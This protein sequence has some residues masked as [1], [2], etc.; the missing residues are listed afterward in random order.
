MTVQRRCGTSQ[1]DARAV[2]L[3]LSERK[4]GLRHIDGPPRLQAAK[5]T[6]SSPEHRVEP[7][8]DAGRGHGRI[9]EQDYL[10]VAGDDP[11]SDPDGKVLPALDERQVSV[12]V[13]PAIVPRE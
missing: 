10:H 5:A 1:R 8:D 3:R 4:T 11:N 12:L 7:A 6:I 2:D 13:Q 9:L